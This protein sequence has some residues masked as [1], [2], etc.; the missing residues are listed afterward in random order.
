MRSQDR[1]LHCSAWRGKKIFTFKQPEYII[2]I[3][4]NTHIFTFGGIYLFTNSVKK[5]V[6]LPILVRIF[7]TFLVISQIWYRDNVKTFKIPS[8]YL[9]GY[10]NPSKS[11]KVVD[12]GTIESSYRISYWS[13]IV[14]KAILVLPG[15]LPV[16]L[17]KLGGKEN[18]KYPGK[19]PKVFT[20][21]LVRLWYVISARIHT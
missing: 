13:S 20:L 17:P 14:I 12:V 16:L 19:Y 7:S 5:T 3:K 2:Y 15:Y 18:G 11:S 4:R 1:A 6:L 10:N 9:P 8:G 21:P